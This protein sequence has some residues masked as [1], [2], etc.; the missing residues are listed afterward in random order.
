MADRIAHVH[1]KDVWWADRPTEAGTWGG[2]TEFGAPGRAW[3]FRSLGRGR[4]DFEAVVRALNRI[5]YSGPLSVEWEDAAMDREHGAAEA[6][7]FVRRL[8]FPPSAI[9]FDAQ[10]S[11]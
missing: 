11:S 4:I 8:D 2:H 10:F 3:D 1:M 6:A 5:G 9:V 7:A